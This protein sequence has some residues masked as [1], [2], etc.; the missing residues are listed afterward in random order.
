MTLA[1]SAP[2]YQLTETGLVISGPL[3]YEE[4]LGLG[5]KLYTFY[6]SARWALGDWLAYGERVWGETYAQ[7][8]ELTQLSYSTLTKLA[9]VAKAYP[10]EARKWK[11][12]VS[13]YMVAQPLP[14]NDRTALLSQAESE[15]LTREEMRDLARPTKHAR[16]MGAYQAR[17]VGVTRSPGGAQEL[18]I[19]VEGLEC[20]PG[21]VLEVRLL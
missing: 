5:H 16:R 12:S 7:A 1:I 19:V 20:K 21:D 8:E 10:A 9:S 18:R 13:H 15:R 11:L 3:S 14:A 17:V 2:P 4:W 6:N